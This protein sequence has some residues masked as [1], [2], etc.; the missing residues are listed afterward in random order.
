MLFKEILARYS[1]NHKKCINTL[2]GQKSQSYWKLNQVV[3]TVNTC[4]LNG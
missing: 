2:C 1:E 3:Q 4:A